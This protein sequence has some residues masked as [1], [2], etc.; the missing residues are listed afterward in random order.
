MEKQLE[1]RTAIVTGA[2]RGIGKA[3]A[4][5][6]AMHGAKVAV[7]YFENKEKAEEVV[8]EIE[9]KGGKAIT[10]KADVGNT[11]ECAKMVERV[12]K[13][14]GSIDIL[15]NN[16]AIT[17]DKTFKNSTKEEWDKIMTTDLDSLFNTV[18]PV[19]K[20]M[21]EQGS[22]SIVNIASA[23]GETGF[24]GQVSYSAAKAGVIGFT[25]ALSK[26]VA[27]K[28]VRVNAVSPGIIGGTLISDKIPEDFQKKFVEMIPLRR[29][30]KPEEIASTVFFLAS[31]YSSY[32]TGQV[33]SVNGGLVT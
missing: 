12:K 11:E 28:G 14:F 24:F 17:I 23:S 18:H 7:N 19:I 30:G 10:V 20:I 26:E 31:D 6:L 4:F 2:S 33:L 32:V 13:E 16:A 27:S 8:K 9:I 5:A 3:I 15:V 22:G 25:K 1:G 21:L 29:L